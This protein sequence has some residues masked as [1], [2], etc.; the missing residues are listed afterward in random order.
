MRPVFV[1]VVCLLGVTQSLPAN[2]LS[3]DL[4]VTNEYIQKNFRSVYIYE[5]AR[6]Q[7]FL[8]APTILA[9]AQQYE[10]VMLACCSKENKL[11][12]FQTKVA[13]ITEDLKQSQVIHKHLCRL[14]MSFGKKALKA[15]KMIY[16][17]QQFPRMELATLL[18]IMPD[19]LWEQNGCC[20]GDAIECLRSRA[21]LR[22]SMCSKQ[23]AISSQI[24]DCC[25]K[26][27]LEWGECIFHSEREASPQDLPP[28]EEKFIKGQD[29]CQ[30]FAEKKDDFLDEFAYEYSRRHQNLTVPLVLRVVEKYQDLLGRCCQTENPHQCYSQGEE[31]FQKVLQESQARVQE[32]C[33]HFRN[34]GENRYQ[35]KYAVSFTK[36]APELSLRELAAHID[37]KTDDT[38]RCCMRPEEEWTT[39]A[40]H[41]ANIL[42]GE[43][44]G[45]FANR[46][47]NA[48]VNNCCKMFPSKKLCFDDLKA[49]ETYAPPAFS[50]EPF[51]LHEDWCQLSDEE[52]QRKKLELLINLVK[53]KPQSSDDQLQAAMTDF[54]D[55][56]EKCCQA[57]GP[58]ACFGAEGPKL[59]AKLQAS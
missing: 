2:N 55:V 48:G 37:H 56:V 32:D 52:L 22:F 39:C 44:C 34:L 27:V 31:E 59:I 9:V 46:S 38:A 50:P 11:R 30:Q 15:E 7:P 21:E 26:P 51:T 1:A 53:N 28:T 3:D 24:C 45:F 19:L 25:E 33:T 58:G 35:Q 4:N 5:M 43:I 57:P 41:S 40:E 6:R 49:D 8:Y 54:S 18:N 29:V 23:K 16:F 17:S 42:Y 14:V 13:P 20:E 36:K 10:K 12:C 47:I